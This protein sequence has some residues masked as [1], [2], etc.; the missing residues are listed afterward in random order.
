MYMWEPTSDEPIVLP[1]AAKIAMLAC[2]VL[3]VVIGVY[4]GPFVK[5]AT[6]VLAT[7][8]F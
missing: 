6:D 7:L 4:Q 5:M 3:V 1:S 2:V 8:G